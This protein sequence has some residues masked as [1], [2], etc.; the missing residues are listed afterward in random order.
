LD[1]NGERVDLNLLF[2]DGESQ[3]VD[4]LRKY[5]VSTF[6]LVASGLRS[7]EKTFKFVD[8][9]KLGLE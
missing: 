3:G 7:G 5:G 4:L 1:L 9:D 2:V 8:S 6:E